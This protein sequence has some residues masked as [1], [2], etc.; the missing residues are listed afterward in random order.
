MLHPN[1]PLFDREG[2]K[3]QFH[4]HQM[5]LN[6]AL[7]AFLREVNVQTWILSDS[8]PGNQ[9]NLTTSGL[10]QFFIQNKK[11]ETML[12][13]SELGPLVYAEEPKPE[14][15]S[16]KTTESAKNANKKNASAAANKSKNANATK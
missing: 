15:K 10:N 8:E 12:A 13:P 7:F 9:L 1:T 3:L 11:K 16:N 2:A 4:L 6:S 14:V 5:S